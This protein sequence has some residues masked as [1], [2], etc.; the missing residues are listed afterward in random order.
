MT[1]LLI[2][3]IYL[4]FISLGLPD[5]V[6]GGAWPTMYLQFEVPVSYAGIVTIIIA[7]G[8]IISSLQPTNKKLV[9][10]ALRLIRTITK[11]DEKTAEK[12]FKQSGG[13]VKTAVVMHVKRLNKKQ[14]VGLLKKHQ[15]FL[16]EALHEK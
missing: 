9:Q 11:T 14:A 8:T 13:H 7:L 3:V 2:V 12:L 4:A 1:H 6:F 5:A 16:D 15:G 10:R